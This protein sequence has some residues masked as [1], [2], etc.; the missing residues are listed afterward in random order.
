MPTTDF[1][2]AT[3]S[4]GTDAT[5]NPSPNISVPRDA[6]PP[7]NKPSA[8]LIIRSSDGVDFRV[9]QAILM[10]AS[11][12]FADMLSLPATMP[13]QRESDDQEYR[14]GM[15]VVPVSEDAQTMDTVL[16]FCYPVARPELKTSLEICNAL[17]A[18]RKYFIASMEIE[19]L[20]VF[21]AHAE[22]K[23]LELYALSAMETGWEKEMKIAAKQTLQ[24]LFPTG[25][26]I[27]QMARMATPAYVQLQVYYHKCVSAAARS[28]LPYTNEPFEMPGI[29]HL[30]YTFL[31]CPHIGSHPSST[32]MKVNFMKINQVVE[33][34]SWV[35][36]YLRNLRDKISPRPRFRTNEIFF[37]Y[38]PL[39]ARSGCQACARTIVQDLSDFQDEVFRLVDEAVE[40]IELSV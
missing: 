19:V 37:R 5:I 4:S 14:D 12:V 27:P 25:L 39:A 35:I 22:K 24:N 26:L 7:F 13:G 32:K 6:S 16:R 30:R 40:K 17:R 31:C 33:V 23:A 34:D 2:N 20:E 18:S 9:Q 11:S 36:E 15:P 8:N 21:E 10:E 29:D 3:P 1:S 38:A 28:V